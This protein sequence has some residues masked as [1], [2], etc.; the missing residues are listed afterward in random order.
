MRSVCEKEGIPSRHIKGILNINR[1][2]VG[3]MVVL[4]YWLKEYRNKNGR[5][6]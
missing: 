2:I 3:F 5:K 6:C 4:T 1:K